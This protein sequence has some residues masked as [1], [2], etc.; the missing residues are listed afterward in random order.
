[1]DRRR[2]N[3]NAKTE[4]DRMSD[5][6]VKMV[7]LSRKRLGLPLLET[8]D[9]STEEALVAEHLVQKPEE[10]GIHPEDLQAISDH[11]RGN[12]EDGI[13]KRRGLFD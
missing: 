8:G 10:W 12:V 1:M 13:D 3:S 9:D 7:N 5:V 4:D 6:D 11:I 2:V